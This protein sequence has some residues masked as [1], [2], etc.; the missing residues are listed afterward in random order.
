[1]TTISSLPEKHLNSLFALLRYCELNH[2]TKSL[3]LYASHIF[4]LLFD[5][6]SEYTIKF[7][8]ANY[9]QTGFPGLDAKGK[10][11]NK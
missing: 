10:S 8:K 1:M 6:Q 5:P 2:P 9:T 3:R 11:V 4:D 7:N